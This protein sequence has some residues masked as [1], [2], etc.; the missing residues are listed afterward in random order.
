MLFQI[1]V[2]ENAVRKHGP[3]ATFGVVMPS[4]MP[5]V[6]AKIAVHG[7]QRRDKADLPTMQADNAGGLTDHV[8]V[9][10][11]KQANYLRIH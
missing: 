11:Y 3:N 9:L 6:E 7:G 1:L 8:F 10:L 4:A 2:V 5:S